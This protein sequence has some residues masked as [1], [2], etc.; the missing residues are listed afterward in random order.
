MKVS[1]PAFIAAADITW[2]AADNTINRHLRTHWQRRTRKTHQEGEILDTFIYTLSKH[3]EQHIHRDIMKDR[4]DWGL[5]HCWRLMYLDLFDS[6][7]D[8]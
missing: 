1:T 7:N 6:Y 5:Q 3:H 2:F 8:D 4:L